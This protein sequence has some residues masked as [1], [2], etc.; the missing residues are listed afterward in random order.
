[1]ANF[2]AERL[3]TLARR[4]QI[5]ANHNQMA[6]LLRNLSSAVSPKSSTVHKLPLM[7]EQMLQVLTDRKALSSTGINKDDALEKSPKLQRNLFMSSVITV[8]VRA[9]GRIR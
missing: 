5:K 2:Q 3:L 1:M 6:F 9:V 8:N 4:H 7:R